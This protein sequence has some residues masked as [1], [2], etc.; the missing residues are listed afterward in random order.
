[1]PTD[2]PT[3]SLFGKGLACTKLLLCRKITL[4]ARFFNFQKKIGR[5][6]GMVQAKTWKRYEFVTLLSFSCLTLR[7]NILSFIY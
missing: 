6:R 3:D 5:V 7:A 4:T 1:M 2:R